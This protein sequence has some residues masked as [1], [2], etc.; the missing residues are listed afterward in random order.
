MAQRQP[1]P[2]FDAPLDPAAVAAL[3]KRVGLV[4]VAVALPAAVGAFASMALTAGS[5]SAATDAAAGAMSGPL[6]AE[7]GVSWLFYAS[8]LGTAL[9]CWV[10]GLGL[11]LDG[12]DL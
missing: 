4:L 7:E 11:L 8:V 6:T 2:T 12:L 1:V 10:L 9:G 3:T 5:L